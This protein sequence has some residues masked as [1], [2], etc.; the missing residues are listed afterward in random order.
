MS[1]PEKCQANESR[2]P[3]RIGWFVLFGPAYLFDRYVVKKG[4]YTDRE[5]YGILVLWV[6]L[7]VAVVFLVV[8]WT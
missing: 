7:V 8:D 5:T 2:T 3:F 4:G 6:V 1:S